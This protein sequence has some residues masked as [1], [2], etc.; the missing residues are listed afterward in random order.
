MNFL[1]PSLTDFAVFAQQQQQ[2]SHHQSNQSNATSKRPGSTTG[3]STGSGSDDDQSH[4]S[5]K[6]QRAKPGRK[7]DTSTPTDKRVAQS[8]E[9][10][11][12]F[13]AQ[14][15]PRQRT[16]IKGGRTDSARRRKGPVKDRTRTAT[17]AIHLLPLECRQSSRVVWR[18]CLLTTVISNPSPSASL[19]SDD[20]FTALLMQS[21]PGMP[22]IPTT[23]SPASSTST[24]PSFA[25]VTSNQLIQSP[26]VSVKTA[27]PSTLHLSLISLLSVT[28][29]L[30]PKN[31]STVSMTTSQ[32]SWNLSFVQTAPLHQQRR[33]HLLLLKQLPHS[34]STMSSVNKPS[35]KCLTL[36]KLTTP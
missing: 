6:K 22:A 14:G 13:R 5:S 16:R 25:S 26:T 31:Q 1:A 19:T 35:R 23:A 7:L 2:L 33:L 24:P 15:K 32:I 17:K 3:A 34:L 36:V 10:Q 29:H 8:R 9:A 30:H 18:I 4:H 27:D 20:A 12:A 21:I 28:T 11:R